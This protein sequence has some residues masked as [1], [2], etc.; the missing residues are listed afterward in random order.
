MWAVQKL[1]VGEFL[2]AD[3]SQFTKSTVF[4]EASPFKA[5]A[6]SFIAY[7]IKLAAVLLF[8]RFEREWM[9]VLGLPYLL[10]A[11]IVVFPRLRKTKLLVVL[12]L[13]AMVGVSL[14]SLSQNLLNSGL[15]VNTPFVIF[16][17]TALAGEVRRGGT[18]RLTRFVALV[19]FAY[20]LMV[21]LFAPATG[22]M[23]WGPRFMLPALPLLLVASAEL[24][25]NWRELAW[26]G[27]V[28]LTLIVL[29]LVSLLVQ[30]RGV[31]YL[32][33]DRREGARLVARI[34]QR[35]E[36]VFVT[37]CFWFPQETAAL[38]EDKRFYFVPKRSDLA[39]LVTR[40]KKSGVRRFAYVTLAGSG[41]V[42]RFPMLAGKGKLLLPGNF[43]LESV[44]LD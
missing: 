23:Q 10:F 9:A 13:L 31:Q 16:S 3:V 19:G 2:G 5:S 40:L 38:Y 8:Q 15:L 26:P 22:G 42:A 11:S 33:R 30:I 4:T 1:T 24:W 27:T 36:G 29:I 28:K 14:F 44:K 34:G 18:E 41:D 32:Y 17:L 39:S 12:S 37:D 21:S 35:R 7:K 20:V 6:F 43:L 25:D